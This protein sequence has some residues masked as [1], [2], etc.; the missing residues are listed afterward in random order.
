MSNELGY[1]PSEPDVRPIGII[2]AII[3]TTLLIIFVSSIYLYK[4]LLSSEIRNK[5][6]HTKTF[7]TQKLE[8]YELEHLN[9]WKLQQDKNYVKIPISK[10]KSLVIKKYNKR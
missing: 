2:I 9:S 4:S 1:D 8:M 7:E 6:V 3:T 10:A 5:L